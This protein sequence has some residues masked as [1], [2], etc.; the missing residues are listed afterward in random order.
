MT[1]SSSTL[2]EKSAVERQ[3]LGQIKEVFPAD[4]FFKTMIPYNEYY[5]SASLHSVPVALMPGGLQAA[6][7]FF[8]LAMELKEKESKKKRGGE[9]DEHIVGLF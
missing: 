7:P 6:R 4:A 8:E 9:A 5:E 2:D 3:I 1:I